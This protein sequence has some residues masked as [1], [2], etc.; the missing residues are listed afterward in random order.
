M[1]TGDFWI[2]MFCGFCG[3]S[4]IAITNN[5]GSVVDSYGG[6]PT[7]VPLLFTLYSIGLSTGKFTIGYLSDRLALYAT[8]ATFYNFGALLQILCAVSF[9]TFPVSTFYVLVFILGVSNGAGASMMY[10]FMS[11]RFGNLYFGTNC[12]ITYIG[13]SAS[14][15]IFATWLAS[16]IYEA[17]ITGEGKM[18]HGMKCFQATFLIVTIVCVI[19][20][21][22]GLVLMYRVRNI[23][24]P[25]I[26]KIIV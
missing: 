22:S 1:K 23:N 20:F 18:C 6:D 19:G 25:K 16:S 10:A 13:S 8:R 7:I 15:Y 26:K 21:I 11:Q 4:G 14:S 2:F 3:S 17:N 24:K 5:L 12:T 9:A